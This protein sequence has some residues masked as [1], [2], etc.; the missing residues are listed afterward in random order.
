MI[1]GGAS[2]PKPAGRVAPPYQWALAGAALVGVCLAVLFFIG[3]NGDPPT[4]KAETKKSEAKK[5]EAPRAAAPDADDRASQRDTE[6]KSDAGWIELFNGRDFTGWTTIDGKAPK[7]SVQ[8]GAMVIAPGAGSV[9]TAAAFPLDFELHAE[10]WLPKTPGQTGQRKAN[11]GIY[12]LGRYE[13]QILDMMDNPNIKPELACGALYDALA[14]RPRPAA[15]PEKWQ[16]FDI[17]FHS[18]R[19]DPTTS[20]ITPGRLTVVHDGVTVIDDE[21][22][23]WR[24]T[25]LSLSVKFG[26]PGPIVLQDHGSPVRFRNLRLRPIEE[27]AGFAPLFNGRDLAG[28]RGNASHWSVNDG[29]IVGRMSRNPASF[30]YLCSQKRYRNFELAIKARLI[31]GNSGVSVR[32][33]LTDPVYFD[34]SGPHVEIITRPNKW[35]TVVTAPTHYPIMEASTL[36]VTS[37][38]APVGFNQLLITCRGKRIRIKLN[39]VTVNEGEFPTMPEEGIIALQLHKRS[40]GMEVRFKEIMIREL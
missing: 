18:P 11:S 15:G 9:R 22:I 8:N 25:P 33:A 7:W 29:E 13:I 21:A 19:V 26:E 5:S 2:R 39:G 4:E 3:R 1:A 31:D 17:T 35:G 10:F 12:L 37:N 16:A 36:A 40:P 24:S 30:S 23:V 28:W 20:A 32:S 14:A 27:G 38:L 6:S 34:V